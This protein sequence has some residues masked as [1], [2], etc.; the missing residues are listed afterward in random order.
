MQDAA[1]SAF[2]TLE[3]EAQDQLVPYLGPIIQNLMFAFSKYQTKNL[4]ILYD[5]LGTLADSVGQDLAKPEFIE[6]PLQNPIRKRTATPQPPLRQRK[7]ASTTP[8]PALL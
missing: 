2:A 3:E 5:T 6:A 4:A 1:C 8:S 7:P